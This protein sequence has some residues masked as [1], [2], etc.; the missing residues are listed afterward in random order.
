VLDG[1]W[2]RSD[3]RSNYLGTYTFESLEA[4]E[5]GLPRSYTRR[6]GDPNITYFN[7]QTSLYAQDDIRVSRA[8]TL[9][10]GIRY[11]IQTHLSDTLNVGPR[12]GFTW[13][14]F[15]RGRTSL[16]ASA[17]IFY[18]WMSFG[19]YEQTLRVDGF[20]QQ[21]LNIMDPS[22]P[23]PGNTGATPPISRYFLGD[24][25][26]MQRSRR[27]SAGID[28]TVTPQVRFNVTYAYIRGARTW[29]GQNLNQPLDGVRPSP[30]FGN[31]V[32]VNRM[33]PRV[34]TR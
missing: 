12:F 19:T 28:Q 29:R 34:S 9:S 26:T 27:L 31:I 10:P 2:H 24:D 11:E 15:R 21:E 5:E 18:D 25:L 7:M 3:D 8:L 14:P 13:A 1:G 23:D 6:I 16:R 33:A 30:A 17:G 32:Q 22:Y 4:F 20:R